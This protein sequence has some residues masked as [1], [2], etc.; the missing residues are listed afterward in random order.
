VQTRGVT[1][2][3]INS[4]ED[5]ESTSSG[6]HGVLSNKVSHAIN[7]DD[8]LDELRNYITLMDKYSL[9]NFMIYQGR[10]LTDTPEF[11]SF[12]RTYKYLWGAISQVISQ[13][14]E[15]LRSF[16]VKLAIIN[17]P[18]L[19]E[20]AQLNHPVLSREDIF[21]VISNIDQ[22]EVLLQNRDAHNKSQVTR[23]IIKV[24]SVLRG[25]I[26]RVHFHKMLFRI[27]SAVKIQS[28]AR[29]FVF[30]RRT[31]LLL[32]KKS[33]EHDQ[34][35][36]NNHQMLKN[37]WKI[38]SE[39]TILDRSRLIV[40]I[41]SISIAEYLRM[42]FQSFRAV[43]NTH[44]S[45]LYMLNDPEVHLLYVV[46]FAVSNSDKAYHEKLLSLLGVS[47]LP[48]RLHFV[49][50]EMMNSLPQHLS[51]SSAL[52][53]STGA[54]NR[55]RLFAKRFPKSS[56]LLT[57]TVGWAEK[58]LSSYL[59]IGILSAEPSICETISSRS[60]MKSIYMDASVNIPIGSHD[61][62]NEDDLYVALSRLIASNIGVGRWLMRLN[63]DWNNESCMYF[64]VNKWPLVADLRTE[65]NQLIREKGH[66]AMWFAKE[67]QSAVRKRVVR[68]LRKDL[69][70]KLVISRRDIYPSFEYFLRLMK[71]FGAVVE[72]EPMEK[73]GYVD[74][75]CFVD[76]LGNVQGCKG[77]EVTL[78]SNYQ[79][80]HYS[81]PQ[82]LTPKEAI[83]GAT[84]AIAKS[85]FARFHVIGFLTVQFL[86]FWDA[87]DQMPRMWAVGVQL[88][89]RSIFGAVGTT[90]LA[91]KSTALS[92]Q[93]Q[94]SLMYDIPE[95]R[96]MVYIPIV[97]YAPLRSSH[98]DLFFKLCRMR[99]IAFDAKHR[100]GT[101]FLLLDSV[102][103][104]ALS[105]LCIGHTR[106][107][108][109]ELA[110]G[111]LTFVTR[112]FGM[113]E[114][115]EKHRSENLLLMLISMKKLLRMQEKYDEL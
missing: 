98:D 104:G 112:E 12:K 7:R 68:A 39:N 46:P 43:Q 48:K 58:R 5:D 100:I 85:L 64:D 69:H 27:K 36:I 15:F 29:M 103:G 17:G 70:Q 45:T 19:F 92:E 108:A 72:A 79:A 93:S 75:I 41:P 1:K 31:Q 20:I 65:Q 16:E 56:M 26:A 53:Y 60:F 8:T 34:K 25:W 24:Q 105:I 33:I 90:A 113:D 63:S 87:H 102:V 18:K 59:N 30:Q 67:V 74:G 21:S 42:D 97:V 22:I 47:V 96:S 71:Q 6:P 86:S 57:S 10:S 95:D 101:I 37:W 2:V 94:L 49:T 11:Q 89:M 55:I 76:P 83:E 106:R 73:L 81:Y 3:D 44:I 50:P 35:L 88:G 52:W 61:I 115:T 9:H 110:V 77:V 51:L 38:R 111:A 40:F 54:L 4:V 32:Q 84:T 23:A 66:A 82:T 99:G 107:K 91:C 80:V 109:L 14:E 114:E 13:L 62:Y 28:V 78:N